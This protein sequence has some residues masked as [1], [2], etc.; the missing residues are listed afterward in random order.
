MRQPEEATEGL[1]GEVR[2]LSV[3]DFMSR[4][5]VT[6]NASDDLALAEQMLRLGGIRHLPVVD[7]GKVL[8]M[9]SKGDFRGREHD[10]IEE[11]TELWERI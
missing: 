10:R 2:S 5:L 6:V 8:G 4:D 11:E 9:V 1:S 3:G 7:G